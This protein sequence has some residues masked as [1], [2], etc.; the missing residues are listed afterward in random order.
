MMGPA[1]RL[2]MLAGALLTGSLLPAAAQSGSPAPAATGPAGFTSRNCADRATGQ[3]R[4]NTVAQAPSPGL[5]AG[6]KTAEEEP[7]GA[8]P[9]ISGSPET[10]GSAP[11]AA[12][13]STG[14][15]A[16]SG[17]E[18]ASSGAISSSGLPFC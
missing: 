11:N 17:G 13:N 14:T 4:D 8:T 6:R 5:M 2:G 10:E 7:G 3:V 12:S 18:G 16:V 9:E 15:G 1:I